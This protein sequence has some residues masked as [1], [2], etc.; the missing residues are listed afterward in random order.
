MI[1]QLVDKQQS[2]PPLDS[3]AAAARAQLQGVAGE[4]KREQR[5][6]ALTDSLRKVIQPVTLYA[7]RLRRLPWPPPAAPPGS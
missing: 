3:L 4:A 7:D 2:V 1:F 6:Q 5:L